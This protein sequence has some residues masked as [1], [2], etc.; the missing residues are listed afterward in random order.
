MGGAVRGAAL[1]E[2]TKQGI[3]MYKG[4]RADPVIRAVSLA[5]TAQP[6]LL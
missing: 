4:D 5:D 6:H 3:Q 2:D 1:R